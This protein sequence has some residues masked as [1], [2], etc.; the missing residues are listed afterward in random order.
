MPKTTHVMAPRAAETK[1]IVTRPAG[2]LP[3]SSARW[4]AK[5]RVTPV[6]GTVDRSVS[7][8]VG[9]ERGEG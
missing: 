2:Y 8:R 5:Y 9:K 3:A 6:R 1:V 4:V 7:L